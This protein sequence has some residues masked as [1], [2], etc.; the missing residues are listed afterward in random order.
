MLHGKDSYRVEQLVP[1]TGLCL[2]ATKGLLQ[3]AHAYMPV[4]V[5][6]VYSAHDMRLTCA[7]MHVH[8]APKLFIDTGNTM[9]RNQ[10]QTMTIDS[11]TYVKSGILRKGTR[12]GQLALVLILTQVLQTCR[13]CMCKCCSSEHMHATCT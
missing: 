12:S 7:S 2:I 9:H 3:L 13:C 6:F 11:V 4:D 8:S 5:C 1:G 10:L